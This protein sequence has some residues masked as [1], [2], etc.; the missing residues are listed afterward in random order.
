MVILERHLNTDI[1]I[2][3]DGILPE[4]LQGMDQSSISSLPIWL[5]R[6]Q[7]ELGEVFR[8]VVNSKEDLSVLWQGRLSNVHRMGAGLKWGRI[9]I[10]G[11]AGR[12]VG[13]HMTGGN[14]VVHGTAGDFAGAEM[15][16]G[17][18]RIEGDAGNHLG[19]CYPGSRW[20][21]NRGEILVMGSAGQGVGERMR[22]GLIAIAGNVGR[23]CGWN[24]WAGSIVVGGN[25]GAECGLEMVRGTIVQL[26]RTNEPL[27][28]TFSSGSDYS[29]G[30]LALLAARLKALEFG[31]FADL[32][33]RSFVM[34]HGDH[35]R[36][37]RG[38]VLIAQ[39]REPRIAE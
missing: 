5:G 9:E 38:E 24:L 22:R 12:H 31:K 35:L 10:E 37:G 34:H 23:L 32:L 13:S 27:L 6:Q 25:C 3:V 8:V 16:G 14:I 2:E 36:G 33:T 7:V 30:V 1:P 19:G 28:P 11:N 29:Q 20:G 21:V 17:L 18:I 39:S 15:R 26:G 4:R